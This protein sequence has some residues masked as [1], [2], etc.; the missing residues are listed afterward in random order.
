M[1][2]PQ[3]KDLVCRIQGGYSVEQLERAMRGD[4]LLLQTITLDPSCRSP[5]HIWVVRWI[6]ALLCPPAVSHVLVVEDTG[7]CAG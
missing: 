3:V 2:L 5:V 4:C 7:A 6:L 1:D